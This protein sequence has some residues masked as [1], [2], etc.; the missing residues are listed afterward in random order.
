MEGFKPKIDKFK[1]N[2]TTTRAFFWTI[3]FRQTM[4]KSK[5]E[6]QKNHK[7]G[8]SSIRRCPRRN[9]NR[10]KR[11]RST[12]ERKKYKRMTLKADREEGVTKTSSERMKQTTTAAT[13]QTRKWRTTTEFVKAAAA[14]TAADTTV[15]T[16][17]NYNMKNNNRIYKSS[18]SYSS[19]NK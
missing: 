7:G 3:Y 13:T 9:L 6:S 2:Q 5:R 19:R 12:L 10:R 15:A 11:V 17:W 18:G 4:K 8:I 1:A 14:A 16:A